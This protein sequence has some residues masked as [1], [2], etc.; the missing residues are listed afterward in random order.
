MKFLEFGAWSL[1]FYIGQ[2]LAVWK[3]MCLLL[4]GAISACNS[5]SAPDCFQRT[6][7]IAKAEVVLP[8][9][10]KITVFENVSLVLRQGDIQ[11]VEIETGE[12]LRNEV[13]ATVE[14]DRLLLRDTNDCNYVRAYGSTTIYVTS[15]N[16]N[17]IRS[18]T[19]RTI[20][21]DGVLAYPSLTLFS[22]SFLNSESE[23]TDGFFD[24]AV[25]TENLT[26]IVNGIT[27]FKLRGNTNSLTVN[28]AAGDS[29][30][31]AGDLVAERITIN[32]RGSNNM[33]VNPQA[34]IE[35][36]IR[37]TGD[38]ISSNRPALIEVEELYKGRLIFK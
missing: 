19:G 7:A 31:E 32:H 33:F 29:R 2:K 13:T 6:G 23:T 20:E 34:A 25:A 9:F 16:I 21:S 22:E 24:L 4:V 37:G 12:N 15:P 3:V 10:S 35:G 26:A 38:V 28:I 17:E 1:E 14:G 36:V 11:K 18:S 5:D 8:A 30:I 27:Y